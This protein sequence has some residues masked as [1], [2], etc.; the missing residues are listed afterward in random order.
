MKLRKPTP[1]DKTFYYG[2][3]KDV[4]QDLVLEQTEKRGNII[5]GSQAI[6]AR[7]PSTY[8]TRKPRDWDIHSKTPKRDAE[9][10]AKK[11]NK[12]YGCN[13][14]YV[15]YKTQYDP[16]G[17]K[18]DIYAVKNRTITPGYVKETSYT[19]AIRYSPIKEEREKIRQY[20]DLTEID[21]TTLTSPE[22]YEEVP[23]YAKERA[24]V[25]GTVKVRPVETVYK[26]RKRMLAQD[27]APWRRQKD[28]SVISDIER[29]KKVQKV[30][31]SWKKKD[32]SNNISIITVSGKKRSISKNVGGKK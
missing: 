13:M 20:K 7:L 21:Y 6:R 16:S 9:E 8:M 32:I 29:Y 10:M 28:L 12:Y 11:L 3:Y 26:H 5:Y 27:R 22:N 24:D 25:V 1:A 19:P 2:T 14:F 17:K 30:K 18:I 31:K 15:L 23:V 4:I